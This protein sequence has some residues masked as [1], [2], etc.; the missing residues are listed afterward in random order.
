MELLKTF[1]GILLAC[2]GFVLKMFFWGVT[3]M[4]VKG[5]F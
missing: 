3:R 1:N 5:L 2:G 4:Y